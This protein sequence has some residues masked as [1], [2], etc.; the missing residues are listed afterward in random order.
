MRFL[1]EIIVCFQTND[2][3]IEVKLYQNQGLSSNEVNSSQVCEEGFHFPKPTTTL[4]ISLFGEILKNSSITVDNN[5]AILFDLNLH[6]VSNG[7]NQIQKAQDIHTK[8]II[9]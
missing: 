7:V 3:K 4:E 2:K 6:V 8:R 9:D 1:I 5:A